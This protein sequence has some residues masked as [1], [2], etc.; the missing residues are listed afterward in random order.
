MRESFKKLVPRAIGTYLNMLSLFS[1]A[2]TQKKAF[3]LFSKPRRGRIGEHHKA[4]LDN[5]KEAR[6]EHDGLEI[7]VYHWPGKGPTILLVHGWESNSH[8]WKMLIEQLI[9]QGY[10]IYTFDAPAHG[11]ST[12]TNL[13][14]PLYR[15]VLHTIISRYAPQYIIG[16]SVGAMTTLYELS[17]SKDNNIKKAVLLGPPDDLDSI[18]GEYRSI[19]GLRQ[20]VMQQLDAYF[21][22][23]FGFKRIQT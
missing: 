2:R 6:V 3:D 18:L 12:G 19:L 13:Y 11:H 21:Q 16:H 15:D 22:K 1:P 14:V 17:Q 7:Q 8:R 23:R 9:P 10:D 4:F 5:A 20:R